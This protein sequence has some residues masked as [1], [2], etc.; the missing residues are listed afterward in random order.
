MTPEFLHPELVRFAF[1]LGVV[2][3][4]KFYDE[5]HLTTGGIAVPAYLGFAV[6]FPLLA[7]LVIVIALLTFVLVHLILPRFMILSAAAKFSLLVVVSSGFHLL[8]DAFYISAVPMDDNEA[9]LRGLG[10]VVPGLIAHDFSRHGV[11]MTLRNVFLT[12]VIVALVIAGLAFIAPE[13]G[14]FY[15]SENYSLYPVT[16]QAMPMLVFLSLIAWVGLTRFCNYRC[17]GFLGGAFMTLLILQPMELAVFAVTALVTIWV[18]KYWVEPYTILFGR[19]KFAAHILVGAILSWLIF[20]FRETVLVSYTISTVT[21]SLAVVGVLLTGLLASDLER[22]GVYRTGIGV[23]GSVSFTLVGTLLVVEALTYGIGGYVLPL[24]I[25]V[26][27]LLLIATLV[28]RLQL[29]NQN[30]N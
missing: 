28:M 23:L 25:V 21:P 4:I 13:F 12:S 8:L 29:H 26:L 20:I 24:V 30:T 27:G 15:P 11:Q 6:F 16:L 1:V 22:V 3:S 7:P 19:R 10:Y 17:G 18:V 14:R 5:R 2:I 9:L